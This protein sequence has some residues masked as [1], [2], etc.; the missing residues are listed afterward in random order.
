MPRY[1]CHSCKS[2]FYSTPEEDEFEIGER[3]F[4]SHCFPRTRL[5]GICGEMKTFSKELKTEVGICT[6]C[7][8]KTQKF[9]NIW[10]TLRFKTFEQ[11]NFTCRYC[12]KS[13]LKDRNIKLHCDHIIPKSKGGEDTLDNLVTSCFECN[14]GKL[15]VLLS[16][17]N[18]DL[19]KNR[20]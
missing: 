1:I 6:E 9:P 4:C 15:D 14:I 7:K 13:P 2:N 19:V 16:Q 20:K 5:C 3:Y 11:D 18:I 8:G 17:Y 12:G 10:L